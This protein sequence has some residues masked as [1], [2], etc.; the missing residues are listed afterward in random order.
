M[1]QAL[2]ASEPIAQTVGDDEWDAE[3]T[4]IVEEVEAREA[5]VDATWHN[6]RLDR[7]LVQIAPE[8]SRNHLQSLIDIGCVTI[9]GLPAKSASRKLQAG[10]NVRIELQPTAESRAF[11]AEALHLDI[12][13]EDEH[14]LVLNKAA[15]MV[16][17]PASGNWSGTVMNGLLAHHP[18]A[19]ALPRAGIVHRLDKDTTGLMMVGK[20]REAVTAL[21]RMIGAREVHREYLALVFGRV[22][23]QMEVNA[24]IRRDLI[25]RI[26][27]AVLATG[28]P[29][30]TDVYALG[31]GEQGVRSIS[32]VHCV[33]H[34]GRTHQIRV[35]LAYKGYP[36]VADALY[37]GVPAL[38]LTRQALHAARLGFTHPISGEALQ[39]DAP[40]P[41]DL[42]SAWALL[43][44]DEPQFPAS[45]Y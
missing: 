30:R 45:A 40:L 18:A 19:A 4:G 1:V 17:H 37:G 12:V 10:Q 38:G 22:P 6:Q 33:L 5:Q 44:L 11:K 2:P 8:F 42:A 41:Q 27:M 9:N 21:T 25:S 7:W 34:S 3:Q 31:V 29:S 15:G 35:H 23:E 36:L 43:G 24:P 20:S 32:A 13:Y 16:V 26:K 28:K 39:F 14:L